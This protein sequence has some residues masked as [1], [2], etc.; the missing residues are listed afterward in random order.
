[1]SFSCII[2]PLKN[3]QCPVKSIGSSQCE[4]RVRKGF[5]RDILEKEEQQNNERVYL[6]T[7]K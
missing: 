1:M 2:N 3:V 4:R 5:S 6:G 7:N